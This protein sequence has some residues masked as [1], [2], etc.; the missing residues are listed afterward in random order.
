MLG[1]SFK[2]NCPDIRNSKSIEIVNE[3]LTYALDVD[4][5]DPVANSDDSIRNK[6]L[7]KINSLTYKSYAGIIV[8]VAHDKFRKMDIGYLRSFCIEDGIIF[9]VKNLY[10]SRHSDLRL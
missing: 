10:S 5:F 3:L 1:L 2:E 6:N 9:D 8:S 4:I 7:K